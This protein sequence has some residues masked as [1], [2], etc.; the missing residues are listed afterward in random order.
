T[1]DVTLDQD[2]VAGR[3]VAELALR[4]AEP[5]VADP[6]EGLVT[7]Q[8]GLGVDIAE[9]D[10]VAR[11]RVAEEVGDRVVVPGSHTRLRQR[12]EV[13]IVLLAAAGQDVGAE[14]SDQDVRTGIAEQRVVAAAAEEAV[15]A[16]TA[17]DDVVLAIA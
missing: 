9:V 10:P 5:A 7:I 4:A 15:L 12:V 6:V 1:V 14:A 13:E 11:R 3:G 17:V 8:P 2:I 16:R